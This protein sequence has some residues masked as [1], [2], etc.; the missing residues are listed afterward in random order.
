[1]PT[2]LQGTRLDKQ[3]HWKRWY[4]ALRAHAKRLGLW[5]Y[6]DPANPDKPCDW[7][8][9]SA[10]PPGPRFADFVRQT[11]QTP[12][13]HQQQ[14]QQQQHQRKPDS[15]PGIPE[16]LV[17]LLEQPRV[18]G[19]LIDSAPVP[20]H[21]RLEG[22]EDW[23]VWSNML[24]A[25]AKAMQHLE[26]DLKVDEINRMAKHKPDDYEV[27]YEGFALAGLEWKEECEELEGLYDA[28]YWLVLWIL[29]TVSKDYHLA[30]CNAAEDVDAW[31]AKLYARFHWEKRR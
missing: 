28:R 5:E 4:A 7:K 27:D 31:I 24:E 25:S 19:G 16:N 12:T 20:S 30:Y 26:F 2:V 6:L 3:A 23:A 22:P 11:E 21:V 14:Q 13:M 17:D 1:M 18:D 29:S 8:T 9:K 15:Q 10:P